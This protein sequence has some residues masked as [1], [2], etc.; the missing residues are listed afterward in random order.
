MIQGT[1]DMTLHII[2][3]IDVPPLVLTTPATERDDPLP[4]IDTL[5]TATRDP[6]AHLLTV[7]APGAPCPHALSP[8]P[9]T[10][11]MILQVSTNSQLH[12]PGPFEVL[13]LPQTPL[14]DSFPTTLYSKDQYTPP[15][16]RTKAPQEPQILGLILYIRVT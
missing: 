10:I 6:G 1:I 9:E 15:I 5:A 8:E 7:L 4:D 2:T 16:P 14:K 11:P 12:P 13:A 3:E